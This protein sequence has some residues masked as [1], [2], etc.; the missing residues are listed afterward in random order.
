VLYLPA[1]L[2]NAV[3]CTLLQRGFTPLHIATKYG[4]LKVVRL[5]LA[6]G[7]DPDVQGKNSLTALHVATHYNHVAIALY[8]LEKRASPHCA[9]KVKIQTF[10]ALLC[11]VC[12]PYLQHCI[13]WTV[14]GLFI[15][16]ESRLSFQAWPTVCLRKLSRIDLCGITYMYTEVLVL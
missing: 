8:L 11:A 4:H 7:I 13:G 12:G 9:T 15:R 14:M 10:S 16:E 2:H 6:K 5:L 3:V 1:S